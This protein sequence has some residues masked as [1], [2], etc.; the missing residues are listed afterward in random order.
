MTWWF[1]RFS[2]CRCG[3]CGIDYAGFGFLYLWDLSIWSW[4]VIWT[5]F[6]RNFFDS[7]RIGDSNLWFRNSFFCSLLFE[8]L[9]RNTQSERTS[10]SFSDIRF[11]VIDNFMNF[12]FNFRKIRSKDELI[13]TSRNTSLQ[14]LLSNIQTWV[15]IL[16]LDIF[17]VSLDVLQIELL[18]CKSRCHIPDMEPLLFN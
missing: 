11:Q 4:Q 2:S 18:L 7:G 3:L 15:Q 17:L 9:G 10:H 14:V 8:L 13:E 1:W 16:H 6:Y 12:F 5:W